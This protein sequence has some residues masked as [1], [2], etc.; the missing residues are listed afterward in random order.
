[1]GSAEDCSASCEPGECG[2]SD[3]AA[4]DPPGCFSMTA[5][6]GHEVNAGEGTVPESDYGHAPH[7]S[8][9]T[10]AQ[11][12]NPTQQIVSDDGTEADTPPADEGS[13]LTCVTPDGGG[14]DTT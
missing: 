2:K 9:V 4:A 6:S 10:Y 7:H 13:M 8:T 12:D 3:M 14:R 5:V 1:M 11:G